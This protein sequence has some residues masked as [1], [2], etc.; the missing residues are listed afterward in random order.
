MND[1][2]EMIETCAEIT[3]SKGFKTDQHAT[4]ISLIATEVA[5]ALE[6][7]YPSGDQI[8]DEFGEDLIEL[9]NAFE[10]YRRRHKGKPYEDLSK[11]K[12]PEH[13][14]EELAD[15]CIRVFSYIGGNKRTDQFLAA[16]VAKIAKNADRPHLHGKSF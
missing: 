7:I 16:M 8:T 12:E 13:L 9:C 15:I 4:Q 6:C 2:K 11:V 10:A 14:D 5:E 3:Q 1:L